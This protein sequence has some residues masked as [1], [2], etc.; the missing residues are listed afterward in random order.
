MSSN[1]DPN[2]NTQEPTDSFLSKDETKPKRRTYSEVNIALKSQTEACKQYKKFKTR[3]FRYELVEYETIGTRPIKMYTW[4]SDTPPQ[5]ILKEK[6]KGK[7]INKCE[8]C[9]K[10]FSEKRN[11]QRH[12]NI[13]AK[14]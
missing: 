2:F 3:K 1:F 6:Q 14:K 8:V 9:N 13:H 12:L 7:D 5:K 11:L 4:V 10:I